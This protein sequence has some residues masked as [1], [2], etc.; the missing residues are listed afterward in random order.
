MPELLL[1]LGVEEFPASF[2]RA[3]FEQLRDALLARLDDERIAHGAAT[4]LGTPRRLIVSVA[5]VVERQPDQTKEQ[6]GPSLASAFAADGSPTPALL[7]FCRSQGVSPD[8]VRKEGDYVW[9]TK[10][11]PGRPTR[12]VLAEVIPGVIE[13]M[14]FPKA[15]R[16]AD[17][18]I[19]FARPIRWILAVLGGETIPFALEGIAAGRVSRGHRFYAPEEFVATSLEELVT[20]LRARYVEPDPRERDK[21]I[22][23]GAR[24]VATGTPVLDDDL[25]EENVF[26]TE[27][28]TAL[29]G[30]FDASFLEL[31]EPVLVTAMA[32][33]ERF[34]PVRDGAGR[35]TNRFVSIRNSGVDDVVRV[36][37]A[38]VLNARFNDAKFFFDEDRK[39]R[40]ADF[41]EATRGMQFQERL[42]T[43]RDRADRLEALAAE[44]A[45]HASW[46]DEAPLAALAGRLA[47]ADLATGL[48]SELPELQG[49]VGGVYARREG[50]DERVAIGIER[51]Y[52]LD[53]LTDLGD[54]G[55][56][57]ALCVLVA[58]QLDKLAGF[59]ALGLA[60]T[61][62]SDPYGLRRAATWLVQAALL[63][64]EPWPSYEPLF[65]R[66]LDG[67][68]QF[69]E[70]ARRAAFAALVEL[71]ASRYAG[72]FPDARYDLLEAALGTAG[73]TDALHPSLVRRRLPILAALAERPGLVY[74][75]TR[76]LNIVE[77]ARKKGLT[78]APFREEQRAD[79]RSPEGEALLEAHTRVASP[80][81]EAIA[82]GDAS[83]ARAALEALQRPIDAFFDSTMVMVEEEAVRDAR[84]AALET[85]N[86]SIR[87]V[88]DLLRIVIEGEAG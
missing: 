4:A 65:S 64:P 82:R 21:R 67:Y 52:D 20:G 46:P 34:F 32:K 11:I 63:A 83:A 19:R 40:L 61:G 26:L 39:S 76:P 36:G 80:W 10:T 62:S 77:A 37:N 27:W 23:E 66:A 45:R 50:I 15:M 31:P 8:E 44:V 3:A 51:H 33:H 81:A 18:R 13:R 56:R 68:P 24:A 25:V 17:S 28:P 16:W 60:P 84:L 22:R 57:I 58:D 29:E 47:K 9:I 70:E 30:E 43:V 5:D 74:T 48:V 38:W 1:E 41:L 35:L 75:C 54:P 6:R 69:D 71:M 42:G 88:G 49:K 7:G 59:L 14:T 73:G 2:V 87:Q 53:S 79:L 12:E 78:V 86:L 72:L 85:V 55:Q